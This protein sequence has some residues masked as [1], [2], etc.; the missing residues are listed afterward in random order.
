[1]TVRA[2]TEPF[3]AV[4][5]YDRQLGRLV[6][7][8]YPRL[9]GRST[10]EFVAL[11]APL[12]EQVAARAVGMAAVTRESA[13]FVVVVTA[14]LVPAGS[15][16]PLTS[17]RGK[18]GFVS[19]DTTDLDRFRPIAEVEVPAAGAYLLLDVDRGSDLCDVRPTDALA[20]IL[21]RGRTPLTYDE[22]IALVTLH[23]ELLEKNH[24]FS[25]VASRCGDKRVPALWI[26]GGAPKLG[27]CWAGNPH[28]WLGSASCGSRVG[29]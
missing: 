7:L 1:M 24:C 16:M 26:S 28:T 13:P 4:A 15:S 20:T 23:P 6:D 22:G 10:E 21:G 17:L 5:E 3:D 25:L 18:P 11:L 9:T 27:W 12:R 2:E 8:G 14:D 29:P 19:A